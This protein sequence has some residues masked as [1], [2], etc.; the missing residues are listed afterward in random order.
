MPF[1]G[2][3]QDDAPLGE[4]VAVVRIFAARRTQRVHRID[5]P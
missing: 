5:D 2:G 1:G 3:H 4:I